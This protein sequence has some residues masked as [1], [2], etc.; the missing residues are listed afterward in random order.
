M[1]RRAKNKFPLILGCIVILLTVFFFFRKGREWI[2]IDYISL[3]FILLSEIVFFGETYWILDK[4]AKIGKAFPAAS[5]ITTLFIYWMATALA[6]IVFTFLL[7]SYVGIFIV[8]QLL[9]L[10]VTA[11]ICLLFYYAFRNIQEKSKEAVEEGI[12]SWIKECVNEVESLLQEE[13][14]QTYQKS[15]RKLYNDLGSDDTVSRNA[16]AGRIL[17]GKIAGLREILKTGDSEKIEEEI[18]EIRILVKASALAVKERKNT[19]KEK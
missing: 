16:E 1:A 7:R 12:H 11:I 15:L 5:M 17:K 14:N 9:F 6:S 8:L 19:A 18:Q 10:C 13:N 3:F 4:K 2:A